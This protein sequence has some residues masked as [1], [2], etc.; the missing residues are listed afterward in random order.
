MISYKWKKGMSLDRTLERTY[1][2]VPKRE[3]KW[4]K[5]KLPSNLDGVQPVRNIRFMSQ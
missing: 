4:R 5:N 1:D 2:V 3:T